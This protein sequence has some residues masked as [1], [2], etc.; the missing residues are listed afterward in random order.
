MKFCMKL[1]VSVL[2][3][4]LYN[5]R[6]W[7]SSS[8]LPGFPISVL[9]AGIKMTTEPPKV[10]FLDNICCF[11]YVLEAL[12]EIFLHQLKVLQNTVV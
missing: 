8:S 12:W 7:L 10:L 6:L 3:F 9:Q 4:H 2:Y 11:N 1:H 5:F